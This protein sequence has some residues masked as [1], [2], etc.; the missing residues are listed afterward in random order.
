MENDPPTIRH[1]RVLH[2]EAKRRREGATT[3]AC[4][5]YLQGN[6]KHGQRCDFPHPTSCKFFP[7]GRCTR[8]NCKFAHIK[9]P[10]VHHA[11]QRQGAYNRVSY[12]YDNRNNNSN[13][14]NSQNEIR[15]TIKEILRG[16]FGDEMFPQTSTEDRGGV[17]N[18]RG[19]RFGNGGQSVRGDS[20][21]GGFGSGG[22]GG[23][24]YAA[25]GLGGDG[26]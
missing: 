25:G 20:R 26:G 23:G 3:Q 13:N 9:R 2:S 1:G 6:C 10:I 5:Y 15:S 17:N 12:N 16:M 11:G 24:R 21:N 18:T 4:K 22:F 19:G 7:T 14:M 8:L